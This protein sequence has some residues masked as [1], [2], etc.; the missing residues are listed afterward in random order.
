M[1]LRTP[2]V[3]LRKGLGTH[4]GASDDHTSHGTSCQQVLEVQEPA[5]NRR[6]MHRIRLFEEECK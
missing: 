4:Q 5:G 2:C 6:L 3:H 1:H